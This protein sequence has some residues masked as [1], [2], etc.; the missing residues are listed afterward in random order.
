MDARY[1]IRQRVVK[2]RLKGLSE[3]VEFQSLK[4]SDLIERANEVLR[5]SQEII[6][7]V[8]QRKAIRWG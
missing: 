7:R 1:S 4:S 2:D 8:R 6:E 5:R 3:K